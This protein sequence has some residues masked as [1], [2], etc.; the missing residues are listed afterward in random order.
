MALPRVEGFAIVSADGMLANAQGLMPPEM[1]FEADQDFFHEGVKRASVIVNGRHSHERYPPTADKPRL[2]ATRAIAALA[3]DPEN[4]RALLWN[5]KGASI[6]RALNELGVGDGMLAVIGGTE[7]FGLFLPLYDAFHLS[8]APR[9]SLPGGRPVFPQ[10][11]AQTPEQVLQTHGLRP[12][13]K[14]VLD[15]AKGLTLVTW[16]QVRLRG[17]SP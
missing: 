5:P 12:G 11:P 9:V 10:V 14:R 6:E 4:A 7:I 3:R 17:Q 16:E 8:R 13:T 2:T 15:Q 1:F